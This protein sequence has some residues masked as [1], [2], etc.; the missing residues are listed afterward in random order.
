MADGANRSRKRSFAGRLQLGTQGVLRSGPWARLRVLGWLLLLAAVVESP[1]LTPFLLSH[2]LHRSVGLTPV[3]IVAILVVSYAAYTLLVRL[4]ERR[5]AR[6]L[7]LRWAFP[8][9]GAGV[10]MGTGLMGLIYAAL[11]TAGLYQVHPGGT[12]DWLGQGFGSCA[13]ALLEELLFRAVAFRLL[14]RLLGPGAALVVSASLF[15]MAHLL[16]PHAILM[17]ALAIA[18]EAGLLLAACLL[19]TGRVWLAVGLHA[20]WNFTE[21][22]VLGAHPAGQRSGEGRVSAVERRRV[23]TRG[24]ARRHAGRLGCVRRHPVAGHPTRAAGSRGRCVKSRQVTARRS[25]PGFF[26]RGCGRFHG[27]PSEAAFRPSRRHRAGRAAPAP[28]YRSSSVNPGCPSGRGPSG[29]RN[30]RSVSAIGRSLMLASRRRISP[31]ASNAH[32]SLP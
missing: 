10:L 31:R 20:A 24:V 22:P 1:A 21:G 32:C 25:I 2:A 11:L 27:S 13:T 7:A 30:S 17:A 15:G 9:F 16:V 28:G 14:A 4:G 6:E 23:R 8:E 29:Q 12:P 3:L 26:W 18:V 5:V 19:L